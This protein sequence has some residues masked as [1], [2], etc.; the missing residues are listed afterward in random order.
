MGGFAGTVQVQQFLNI[1]SIHRILFDFDDLSRND[2][3]IISATCLVILR[4]S[5][6]P[7]AERWVF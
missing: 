1:T 6:E 2:P 5:T 7:V 3:T 4:G